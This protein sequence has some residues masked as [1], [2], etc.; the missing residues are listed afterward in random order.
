VFSSS[1]LLPR[2]CGK[3]SN[4]AGRRV[5]G[6]PLLT[7]ATTPIRTTVGDVTTTRFPSSC[8]RGKRNSTNGFPRPLLVRYEN[9][10]G[11]RPGFRSK[12]V[13]DEMSD[14][15]YGMSQD[16]GGDRLQQ[17]SLGG[18]PLACVFGFVV[19]LKLVPTSFERQATR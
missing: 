2:L 6:V 14:L 18:F 1:F 8:D 16:S 10:V 9:T 5:F 4:T 3:T 17:L 12:F 19:A 15:L 13:S 7:T 11:F